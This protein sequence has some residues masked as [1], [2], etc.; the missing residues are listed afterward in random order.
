MSF[1]ISD[2]F[3]QFIGD[4]IRL[5]T[6]EHCFKRQNQD[7]PVDQPP[8]AHHV[9]PIKIEVENQNEPLIETNDPEKQDE[10]YDVLLSPIIPPS[11]NTFA[12]TI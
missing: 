9:E 4:F 1:N 12:S 7:E 3:I 11:Y 6:L 5:F 10:L 8:L 2:K